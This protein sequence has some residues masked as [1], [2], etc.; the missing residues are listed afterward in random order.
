MSRLIFIIII[1]ALVY[2]LFKT[3]RKK[4]RTKEQPQEIQ[5]MIACAYCGINV[6]QN[7]GLLVAGKYYCCEE[8]SRGQTDKRSEE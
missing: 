8:H 7:D 6:P 1:F 2:L 3:Y 5:K 4:L